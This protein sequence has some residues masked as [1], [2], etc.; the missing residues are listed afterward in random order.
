MPNVT[1]GNCEDFRKS[2]GREIGEAKD[3]AKDAKTCAGKKIEKSTYWRTAGIG[4]VILLA[5]IGGIFGLVLYNGRTVNNSEKTVAAM[6]E[7]MNATKEKVDTIDRDFRD[8]RLEQRTQLEEIKDLVR[9]GNGG[10]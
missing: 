8:F 4:V 3:L 2:L 9:N 1:T 6:G 5:V 10:D 7:K